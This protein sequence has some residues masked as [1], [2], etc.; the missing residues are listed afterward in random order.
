MKSS[1]ASFIRSCRRRWL[2]V[3]GLVL[4]VLLLAL[5]G[6]S[7]YMLSYSLSPEP[8]RATENERM[9][10]EAEQT[11]PEIVPWID[12]LKQAKA[13]RDTFVV[14]P[15]GER[16]HAFF[17]YSHRPTTRTAVLVHGYHDCAMR[18]IQL[19][20]VYHHLLGYNILLPDLHAHGQSEGDAVQMGW[21]DRLDVLHWTAIA[22]SLFRAYNQRRALSDSAASVK[23]ATQ[24]ESGF[25]RMVV[26]GVSMGAATT[27]ALSGETTPSYIRGFVEDC[28]YTSVWDE[29][30]YEL[31]EQFG[32][33]AFPLMWSTSMLCDLRYGWSFGEAS[34]LRQVAKCRKPMLFIHG[35]AD[36][37]VPTRMVYPLYEAKQGAKM[38]YL[39]PGSQH[40]VSYRDH[41]KEYVT[42][43]RA[44]CKKYIE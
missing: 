42:H 12:S 44:F 5:A 11:Y 21:K 38:L 27:M 1:R 40:A 9:L 35:T 22:D 34:P 37:Y 13:L 17:V 24:S 16:H 30:T 25:T 20:Y 6:A 10:H 43:V 7:F 41:P 26:H 32:L 2:L 19:G 28:G 18:M 15:T 29:F 33:P 39:A 4:V 36:H 14:M 31:K 8:Q 23:G 3:A